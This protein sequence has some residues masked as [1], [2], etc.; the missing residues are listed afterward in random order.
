MEGR[1]V[2]KMSKEASFP[3][4]LETERL[5]LRP[6][7]GEDADGILEL[8]ERNRA[9]LVEEFAQ[10]AKKLRSVE[11]T[12]SFT[13]EKRERWEAR[14]IFCYGIWLKT[15]Q[16]LIGQIQVKNIAWEI[17]S[18]EFGY[19]IDSARQRQ[20]FA[21]ETVSRILKVAFQNMDFQRIF[22][23]LSRRTGKASRGQKSWGFSTKDRTAKR[24]GAGRK[25]CMTCTIL[26]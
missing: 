16:E 26:R 9:P 10:M 18:A 22:C 11:D 1:Q 7:G 6:Y 21:S 20:G 17:P 14:K 12:T 5:V 23:A 19:F 4:R 8:V 13:A 15:A 25:S 2:E 3:E 24:F